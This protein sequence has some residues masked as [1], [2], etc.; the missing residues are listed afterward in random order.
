MILSL[1][2]TPTG[3]GRFIIGGIVI[4]AACASSERRGP[5]RRALFAARILSAII[6]P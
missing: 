1:V 2:F 6:W 4:S 5:L 3:T